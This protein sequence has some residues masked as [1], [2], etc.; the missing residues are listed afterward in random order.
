VVPG[1]RQKDSTTTQTREIEQEGGGDCG[2]AQTALPLLTKHIRP[3]GDTNPGHPFMPG[4]G[5]G[6]QRLTRFEGTECPPTVNLLPHH[7]A[8]R[9]H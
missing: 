6:R 2:K 5:Q 7:Q 3:D 1:R 8:D 9:L 4:Q